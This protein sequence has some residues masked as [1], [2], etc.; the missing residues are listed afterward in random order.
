MNDYIIKRK[1]KGEHM[2]NRI[3]NDEQ[4][5]Q[6]LAEHEPQTE[7]RSDNTVKV[8]KW[9][10]RCGGT[11]FWSKGHWVQNG[12]CFACGGR[13]SKTVTYTSV[14]KYAQQAKADYNRREKAAERRRQAA[15]SHRQN[16]LEGQ[17]RWCAKNG[18][19]RITFSEKK[20]LEEEYKQ[21]LNAA[22]VYIGDLGMKVTVEATYVYTASFDTNYGRMHIHRFEDMCGNVIVWKT[23]KGLYYPDNLEKGD[24]VTIKGTIKDLNEYKGEKQTVLTRCKVER[25]D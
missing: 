1:G 15:E 16:V 25:L 12:V 18:Y 14:K 6:W 5:I 22:K 8:E 21:K 24:K 9:C 20:Q 17:R 11:G 19:G 13:N 10:G 2:T 7:V 3:T 4:A 23:S